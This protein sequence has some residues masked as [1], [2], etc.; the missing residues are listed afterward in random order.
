MQKSYDE[1]LKNELKHYKQI[2]K[3]R[4]FQEVPPI[5][6]E[7]EAKFSGQIKKV[8]GVKGLPEYIAR[9]VK[10]KKKIKLLSLGSGACGVELA[11]IAPLLEKQKTEMELTSVDI[12]DEVL[13][14]AR[15]EADK[16]KINFVGMAQ[17]I[18]KLKLPENKYDVIMAF[19]ALHHFEKLDLVTKE[20]NKAL[21][22]G[23]IFVTV[24]IPTKNGY[25]MWPETKRIVEMIWQLIPKRY[26]WDHTVSK[27]PIYMNKYP[28][29]D[30]SIGSMECAKSQDIIPALRKNLQEVVFVP[31]F[32]FARRFFD[33]KFGPNYKMHNPFDKTL[34]ELLMTVDELLATS[35]ALKPETFFGVYAK[36][37]AGGRQLAKKKSRPRKG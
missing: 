13:S 33:T 36:Q 32:V 26:K 28:D 1:R 18:N 23:G 24:D 31:A 16:R 11:M 12:N 22:P 29:V 27:V 6:N 19:A 5:W 2:F 9:H 14:Q 17:D 3:D 8:T 7:V 15:V 37:Q 20:I 35:G 21:K 30:Y 25:L 4:L 10:G 34:F